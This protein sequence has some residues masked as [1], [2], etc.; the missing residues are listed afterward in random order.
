MSKLSSL[1]ARLAQIK[2]AALA[3]QR[4]EEEPRSGLRDALLVGAGTATGA[5]IGYGAAALLKHRYGDAW[6]GLPPETRIKLLGPIGAGTGTLA[7]LVHVLR[8]RE[9]ARMAREQQERGA[10]K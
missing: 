6:K 4:A 8:Q 10:R 2:T 1:R 5:G 7:G 3:R 9:E